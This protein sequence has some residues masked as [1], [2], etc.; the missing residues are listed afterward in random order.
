MPRRRASVGRASARSSD[1][2]RATW[3]S[4][5]PSPASRSRRS[6]AARGGARPGRVQPARGD[7]AR[8][9]PGA[10]AGAR[11]GPTRSSRTTIACAR[12]CW[13]RLDPAR[14]RAL[15]RV[16]GDRARGGSAARPRDACRPLARGRERVARVRDTQ[17]PPATRRR[18]RSPSIARRGG[19]RPALELDCRGRPAP[20]RAARQARAT[21]SPTRD[22]ARSRRR[23]SRPPPRESPPLEALD[24]RRRARRAAA[25]E[26]P[27]RRGPRRRRAGCSRPSECD[28]PRRAW[29]IFALLFN[30]LAFA[31]KASASARARRGRSPRRSSRGLTRAGRSGWRSCSVRTRRRS[32]F[33][34]RALMLALSA[35]SSNGLSAASAWRPASSDRPGSR[36][37]GP[38]RVPDS[39]ACAKLADRSGSGAN[40]LARAG[41]PGRLSV[42]ALPRGGREHRAVARAPRGPLL[43]SGAR[44]RDEARL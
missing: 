34:T 36:L 43:G 20:A 5:S 40:S 17:L 38:D 13:R 41:H 14:R 21:R 42:R 26:R 22:A 19:T 31:S 6:A 30:A 3:W 8:R 35:G 18:G 9:E 37:L 32:I 29:T 16:A 33:L 10:N 27:L 4:S 12:R 25:P 28:S 39:V 44:T 1:R 24:L 15:A 2:R 23:T 11:G 7:A